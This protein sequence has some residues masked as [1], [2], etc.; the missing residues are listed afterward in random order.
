[1]RG[2]EIRDAGGDWHKLAPITYEE[3]IGSP[4]EYLT[5]VG[6]PVRY[7]L[8]GTEI[9]TF[10]APG[11]GFVTMSSGMAVRLSRASSEPAVTATT[12]EPGFATAF[13]RILSYGAAIDFTQEKEQR[14][15][16]LAQ[17]LR[18]QNGLTKF[19]GKWA[20]QFKPKVRPTTKRSWKLYT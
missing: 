6:L 8:E 17:K 1:V 14:D 11:T 20:P 2:V 19:Y 4:E 13:H 9:R 3:I 16:L 5:G 18:L 10:P 15:F 12:T 7:T